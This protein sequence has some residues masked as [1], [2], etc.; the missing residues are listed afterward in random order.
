MNEGLSVLHH[1]MR[2]NLD[3]LWRNFKQYIIDFVIQIAIDF[4]SIVV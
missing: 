1:K 4:F 2:R 3:N